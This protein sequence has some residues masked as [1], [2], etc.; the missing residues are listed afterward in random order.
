[1]S[2]DRPPDRGCTGR[3]ARLR[4]AEPPPDVTLA[5][6]RAAIAEAR[7][8]EPEWAS[9]VAGAI[10]TLLR[11]AAE[12]PAVSELITGAA[13]ADRGESWRRYS[14]LVECIAEVLA[15]GRSE[16]RDGTSLPGLME[17]ALAGGIVM[18]VASRL[19]QG[20]GEELP[21]LAPEAVQF[22]LTPYVGHE[23]ARRAASRGAS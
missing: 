6:L 20:R 2:K 12:E 1:M 18:L 15:P 21:G 7:D 16:H 9:G 17:D 10:H 19:D 11:F 14:C 4:L 22:A 8:S 23:E 5:K 3:G 13:F